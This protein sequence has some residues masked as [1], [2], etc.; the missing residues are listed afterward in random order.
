MPPLEN[1]PNKPVPQGAE[2][3]Y[4]PPK[5]YVFTGDGQEVKSG[6]QIYMG[7]VGQDW[8][9]RIGP[10]ERRIDQMPAGPEKD[11]ALARETNILFSVPATL[12]AYSDDIKAADK[13][14]QT[15]VS[16]QKHRQHIPSQR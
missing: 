10:S 7:P 12:K 4:E 5:L 6:P 14:D 2:L 1:Q 11:A 3:G 8:G 16:R 13:I 15:D 9:P